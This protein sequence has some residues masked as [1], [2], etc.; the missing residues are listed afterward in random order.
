MAILLK[1]GSIF[2][3]VPK[4]GG[5]WVSLALD[6][7]GLAETTCFHKHAGY[8]RA[9][10]NDRTKWSNRRWGPLPKPVPDGTFMF[11]F[12]RHPLS[13]LVSYWRYMLTVGCP[14]W[15]RMNSRLSW[16]PNAVLNELWDA[17]FT[18]FA[19]NV[20][21]KRPG[22]VSELY[23]LYAHPGVAVYR[24]EDL[25]FS[26]TQAVSDSG[27]AMTK[28]MRRAIEGT[29]RVNESKV[30]R[31]LVTPEARMAIQETESHAIRRYGYGEA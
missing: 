12:V 13:W 20:V 25:P 19:L 3:H 15:G 1:N 8:E 23:S 17:D 28:D 10:T 27:T 31:P 5:D 26:L 7:A 24:Q 2:L 30:A 4:T 16:H 6:N 11:C 14:L 21:D 9:L 18:R 29:P 22:Y